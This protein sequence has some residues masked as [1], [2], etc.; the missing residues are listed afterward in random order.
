M[1]PKYYEFKCA[2]KILSGEHA[3][4]HLPY[5]LANLGA[6]RV[7]VVTDARLNSLGMLKPV[8]AALEDSEI[9]IAAVFDDVPVDS[10]VEAVNALANRYREMDCSGIVAVG[11]GSVLDTA[12]GAGI[13]L[14]TGEADLMHLRGSEVLSNV[15]LPPLVAIP[16]TAGTGAEVTGAAV[17][18]DTQRDVKMAFVSFD[19]APH[20]AVLDPRM[21]GALPPRLTASTAMDALV[22]CVEAATSRQ[23]NPLSTAY[24]HAAIALIRDNLPRAL[25]DGSDTTARLALANA[26]LMAGVAF[27]NAMVAVVHAL[28]HACGA[29]AHVPHGEAMAILLPTAME[30]NAKE[31]AVA[32]TYAELLLPLA[33]SE[34]Y[35]STPAPQRPTAAIRAVRALLARGTAAGMPLRLSEAGVQREQLERIA[36][37]ALD[38]GSIAFNPRGVEYHDALAILEESL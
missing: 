9:E 37:L 14:A 12:K 30:F 23:A 27:S 17:I 28:G 10:A 36:K 18:K 11:G 33:G 1:I 26:A 34:V 20:V 21:T 35:A 24:A 4:E 22:H 31:P 15:T 32:E 5:E 2:T 19:L 16:T 8:I 38:D 13:V 7:L 6:V 25:D 29:V 3:I